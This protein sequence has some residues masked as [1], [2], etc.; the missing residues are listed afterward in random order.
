MYIVCSLPRT[1][2]LSLTSM[3]NTVGLKPKHVGSI[4]TF[5]FIT[6]GKYNFFSDTPF[7]SLTFLNMIKNLNFKLIYV[8]KE[9]SAIYESWK[10]INLLVNFKKGQ[11]LV[12]SNNYVPAQFLDYACYL[13]LF[14]EVDV[15]EEAFLKSVNDHKQKIKDFVN[16]TKKPILYYNFDM[17]WEPFCQFTN[18]QVPTE[19]AIPRLNVNTMFDKIV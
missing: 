3:A 9:P 16:S 18:T 1:G 4:A 12:N 14:K 13:E 19:A 10:K 11:T 6:G 8:E 2:T 7:Y 5:D 17:G 15:T